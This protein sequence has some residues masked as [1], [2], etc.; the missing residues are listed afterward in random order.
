MTQA[1]DLHALAA[2]PHGQAQA[3]LRRLGLWDEH[4]SNEPPAPWVV[5]VSCTDRE[6]KTVTVM[7][8]NEE[9]ACGLAEEQAE[10]DEGADEADALDA[11]RK[12]ADA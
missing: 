7:A 11:K 12:E 3:E 4:A 8:R 9:E 10:R 1:V 2:L 6:T 5:T